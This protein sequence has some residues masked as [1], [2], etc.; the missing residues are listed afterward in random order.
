M[1]LIIKR[2][3]EQKDLLAGCEPDLPKLT[4]EWLIERLLAGL[5]SRQHLRGDEIPPELEPKQTT[6][7]AVLVPLVNRPE[8]LTVLL[9]QRTEHLVDHGGQISFPGGR[10]EERDET[11]EMTAL[12]ETE[13]EIGLPRSRVEIVGNLSEYRTV[14]GYSITPV[15]GLVEPPFA[16]KLD[17]FEVADVFEVPLSFLLDP[18]N[19]Q[20]HSYDYKGLRRFYYA[21]PFQGR[22]IWGATAG[23]LINLFRVLRGERG[24]A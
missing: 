13:E 15:V 3:V 12:R 11:R 21:M 24:G 10:V 14:S 8:G 22:F 6:P 2:A 19:H 5:P 16:L 17:P 9:T 20:R 1:G 4:R 18:A 23:M 7:A